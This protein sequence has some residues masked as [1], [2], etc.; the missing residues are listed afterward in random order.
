L[1]ISLNLALNGGILFALS[2]VSP[3]KVGLGVGMYFG[4][5]AGASLF[6]VIFSKPE[7]ISPTLGALIGAI[8]C[9]IATLCVAAISNKKDN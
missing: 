7:Q 6:G 5:T 9:L 3:E 2:T 1:A 4:G 8:A